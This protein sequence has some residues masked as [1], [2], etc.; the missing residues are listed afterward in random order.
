MY[1]LVNTFN[2]TNAAG[3]DVESNPLHAIQLEPGLKFIWNLKN[4]WQP[5]AGVSIVWNIMDKTDFHVNDVSLPEI[6]VQPFVKYG[7][8]VRKAWGERFT[9]YLQTYLTNGGRTGIGLQAGFRWALGKETNS[10]LSKTGSHTPIKPKA[11]I[12]L[13][14]MK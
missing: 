12:V 8:G 6:S 7:L 2:Y 11:N 4:G 5:Y 13:S 3:I 9:G 1:S 10:T 14:S